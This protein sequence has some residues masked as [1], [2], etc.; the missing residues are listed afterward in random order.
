MNHE[1]RLVGSVFTFSGNTSES[2]SRFTSAVK[3]NST[4]GGN[5]RQLA[6]VSVDESLETTSHKRWN[7]PTQNSRGQQQKGAESLPLF[8]PL[9]KHNCPKP[10]GQVQKAT[11]EKEATSQSIRLRFLFTPN[12]NNN[13]K[14]EKKESNRYD[15]TMQRK[16]SGVLLLC[17]Q[18]R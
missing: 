12:S 13:N 1:C 10:E 2:A 11:R 16:V 3:I 6:T 9:R 18:R 8:L 5:R 15:T 7:A 14:K 4:A 17:E